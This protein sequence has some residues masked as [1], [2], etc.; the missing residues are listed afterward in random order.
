MTL[1]PQWTAY[2]SKRSRDGR[3]KARTAQTI[4]T[5]VLNEHFW[6]RSTNFQEMVAPVV[7]ALW[8]FDAKEPS[9]GKVLAILRDL[10][11]HVLA[12]RTEPFNLDSRSCRETVLCLE[13]D[14]FN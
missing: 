14:D 13:A 7:Y 3:D 4:K 2:I 6:D 1:E 8:K 11:K 12:L 10:E 5:V 9:M